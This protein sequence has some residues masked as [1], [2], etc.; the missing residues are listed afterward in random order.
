MN[1]LSNNLLNKKRN[2]P[3][4]IDKIQ[5]STSTNNESPIISDNDDNNYS[6]NNDSICFMKNPNLKFNLSIAN[7]N[8]NYGYSNLFEIL[9]FDKDKIYYIVSPN[10]KTFNLDIIQ[11]ENNKIIKNLKGHLN[12]I[13]T[14]RNFNEYLLSADVNKIV[15]IWKIND[16]ENDIKKYKIKLKYN[17]WI[18]SC[19]FLKNNRYL[20]TS[21]CGVGYTQMYYFNPNK[22]NNKHFKFCKNYYITKKN[23]TFYI[24]LWKNQRNSKNYIIECCKSK[25]VI[26]DINENILYAK[27][28][29]FNSK[30]SFY[31]SGLIFKDYL[32]ANTMSGYINVWNLYNKNLIESFYI[33]NCFLNYFLLWN[34]YYFIIIDSKNNMLKIFDINNKKVVSSIYSEHSNVY[35]AKKIRH[36][37]YGESLISCGQ[38]N[39]IKL[40]SVI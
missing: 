5:S 33:N 1:K 14:V 18:Y 32:Y 3:N 25:I 31:M 9:Y 34:N 40:F 26:F 21:C 17:N 20:F 16:I 19:Y 38:D 11:L 35:F 28:L 2:Q 13:T 15:I 27:F 8:D 22:E 4:D 23:C 7:T 29:P 6:F 36:P 12:H 10:N 24:I 39:Y 30:N 37:I